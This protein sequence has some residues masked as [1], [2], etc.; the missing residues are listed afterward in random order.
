MSYILSEYTVAYCE[1][2]DNQ[3]FSKSQDSVDVIIKLDV[4]KMGKFIQISRN[5]MATSPDTQ[6]NEKFITYLQK[7]YDRLCGIEQSLESRN[8]VEKN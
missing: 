7:I 1:N 8:E 5:S 4:T 3:L 2:K 6:D